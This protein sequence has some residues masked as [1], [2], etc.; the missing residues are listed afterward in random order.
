MGKRAQ[1]EQMENK[2]QDDTFHP[3][4]FSVTLNVSGLLDS[5]VH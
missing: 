3:N 1:M 2:D 5:I 4:H